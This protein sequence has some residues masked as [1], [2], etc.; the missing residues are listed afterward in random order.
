MAER[1]TRDIYVSIDGKIYKLLYSVYGLT[2]APKLFND[3]LV[4]H[5]IAGGYKQ[6][7]YEK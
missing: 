3:G 4:A 2:D 5:M 1:S 6:S 7:Q